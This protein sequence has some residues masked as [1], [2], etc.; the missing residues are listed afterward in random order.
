M[1]GD[2]MVGREGLGA[3]DVKWA[4]LAGVEVLPLPVEL[5]GGEDAGEGMYHCYATSLCEVRSKWRAAFWPSM[6]TL[7]DHLEK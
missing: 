6:K 7:L 1:V 3:A 2:A 4:E 5:I